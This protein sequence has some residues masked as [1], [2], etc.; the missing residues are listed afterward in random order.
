M[1]CTPLNMSSFSEPAQFVAYNC[2]YFTGAESLY[3]CCSSSARLQNK[4][5]CCSQQ[6][7]KEIRNVNDLKI[8]LA[9]YQIALENQFKRHREQSRQLS[10]L[11]S[12][13]PEKL[14][15]GTPTCNPSTKCSQKPS[16]KTKLSKQNTEPNSNE[17]REYLLN[18][19]CQKLKQLILTLR[20]SP[21][22]PMPARKSVDGNSFL[23]VS[24]RKCLRPQNVRSTK[25]KIA[26][27][28][29][30]SADELFT[31]QPS[32]SPLS[33]SGYFEPSEIE[34]QMRL[35]KSLVD[36]RERGS[37][38]DVYIQKNPPAQFAQHKTSLSDRYRRKRTV[39]FSFKL[40]GVYGVL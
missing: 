34:T 6:L 32:S 22:C 38:I 7:F 37:G 20:E 1:D 9:A 36:L 14:S 23:S 30:S 33:S 13:L 28:R 11:L 31:S 4:L 3:N 24:R 15:S 19:L 8:T 26:H 5:L 25:L 39:S 10:A 21:D 40:T 2:K 16:D 27:R 18:C 29:F 35:S 17:I 12:Y